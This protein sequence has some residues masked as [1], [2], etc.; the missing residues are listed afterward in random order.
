MC[1]AKFVT[2]KDIRTNLQIL[3]EWAVSYMENAYVL[4]NYNAMKAHIVYYSVCH[5]I[6][7]IIAI[8]IEA[9]SDNQAKGKWHNEISVFDRTIA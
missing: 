4:N 9:V 1:H 2:N 3:C 8:R 5:A 6:F 7:H